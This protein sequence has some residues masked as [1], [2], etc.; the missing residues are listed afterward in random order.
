VLSARV[1]VPADARDLRIAADGTVTAL[2]GDRDDPVEL[3]RIELAVFSN[4]GGLNSLGDNLYSSTSESGDAQR[5]APGEAGAGSL[6]QGFLE[7]SNVRMMDELVNL[8]LAQ[9]AFELNSKII[10]AA[11]Q[12]LGVTN[13]LYR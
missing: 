13:G 3:G 9:R 1:Q 10:Q 11:D 12:M 8:M 6:K 4:P 2:V 7:N 5:L